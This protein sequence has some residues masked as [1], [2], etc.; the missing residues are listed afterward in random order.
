MPRIF[1]AIIHLRSSTAAHR[2]VEPT[3]QQ[4]PG[5]DEVQYEPHDSAVTVNFDGDRTGLSE[6]V[7]A[8]EN[9]GINVSGIA[10]RQC[11]VNQAG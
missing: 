11:L 1:T 2:K 5:V 3:L 7:G 10:Q 4:V 8:I 6:L 9:L